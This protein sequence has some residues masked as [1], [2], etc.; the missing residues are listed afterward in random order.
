M[1]FSTKVA[2]NP[3]YV[4]KENW[5]HGAQLELFLIAPSEMQGVVDHQ[6]WNA[7]PQGK[8]ILPNKHYIKFAE[9]LGLTEGDIPS[10]MMVYRYIDYGFAWGAKDDLFFY[11]KK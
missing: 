8:A 1:S 2:Y 7:V 10:N 5:Y 9:N 3:Y 4:P 11:P 6:L